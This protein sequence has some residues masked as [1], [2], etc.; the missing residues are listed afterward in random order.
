MKLLIDAGADQS[1]RNH[2]GENILHAAVAGNPTAGRLR[3]LLDLIDPG[4]RSHLFTHR[5]NLQENGTTPLHTWISQACGLGS[6]AESDENS[7]NRYYH[8]YNSK[9]YS[10]LKVAVSLLELLLEYSHGEELDMLNGPGDTCLHTAIRSNMV[11]LVKVLVDFKPQLLYRENAVGRTPAEIAH[12]RIIEGR[13]AKPDRIQKSSNQAALENFADRNPESFL[14]DESVRGKTSDNLKELVTELGLSDKYD[15]SEVAGILGSIGAKSYSTRASLDD[16]ALKRVIWDLCQTTME[17][18]VGKRRLVSLNEANDV[19][20]R[21][22]EKYTGSRYFS[23]QAR[24]EDE[25]NEDKD[26][27]EV[28]G[29][30]ASNELN[31]RVSAAW[32]ISE[33]EAKEYG[34][35]KCKDC[36]RY[37]E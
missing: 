29:D 24:G 31:T 19:A 35:E 37:H 21:L 10:D 15:A 8:S 33:F 12:D 26:Q 25:E 4:L 7:R 32:T 17:K 1:T 27:E 2:K 5:K 6:G 20:R 36:K 3:R 34:I 11:S 14:A 22:G 9:P 23:I 18:Y 28:K 13:F 16:A 30:F